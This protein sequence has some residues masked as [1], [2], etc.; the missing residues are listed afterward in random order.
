[1]AFDAGTI[2][3]RMAL[4]RRGFSQAVAAV[5]SETEGLKS[6]LTSQFKSIFKLGASL[7]GVVAGIASAIGLAAIKVAQQGDAYE[8]MSLRT[9]WAVESLSTLGYA[10]HQSDASLEDL[11]MGLRSLSIS[12]EGARS[13][14]ADLA[15]TFRDLGV[16]LKDA[17]GSARSQ[18]DVFY[19]LA[20]AIA[21]TESETR[22]MALAQDLFGRGGMALL[23]LLRS[24][25]AGIRELEAQ[26]VRLGAQWK[27][28]EAQQGTALG[29]RLDDLKVAVGG[30]VRECVAGLIPVMTDVVGGLAEW[31]AANRELVATDVKKFVEDLMPALASLGGFLRSTA[32]GSGVLVAAWQLL[33][34]I[35]PRLT[36]IFQ[37][38][39][40]ALREFLSQSHYFLA[41]VAD[42]MEV[43]RL[44][45][46]GTAAGIRAIGDSLAES[47]EESFRKFQEAATKAQRVNEA[48]LA[49]LQGRKPRDIYEMG[50]VAPPVEIDVT[51]S[52]GT[53]VKDQ[54]A[55]A[56]VDKIWP[57]M[58]ETQR[59]LFLAS[60][61]AA[62]RAA[63]ELQLAR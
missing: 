43:L 2:L 34:M 5:K 15:K 18:R 52:L 51:L 27:T 54:L 11:G 41:Q 33:A 22:R 45:P 50:G 24:G 31:I 13:G 8:K 26:G 3:A 21:G 12:M 39:Q 42:I 57:M 29:D 7:V 55:K 38:L 44:I 6:D 47:A 16:P 40:T 37:A 25:A 60:R 63:L 14:N 30:L 23:P 35:G 28:L 46:Q 59:A 19:D 53:D 4:D 9:G 61:G 17:G 10:A 58:S 1:M 20:D 49:N 32:E 48:F 36:G 56:F 62:D